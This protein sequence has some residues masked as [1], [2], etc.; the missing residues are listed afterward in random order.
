MPPSCETT[1]PLRRMVPLHMQF[2]TVHPFGGVPQNVANLPRF[3][4]REH[5][6]L[7]PNVFFLLFICF[8]FS[9]LSPL[10]SLPPEF[11]LHAPL[12]QH[13]PG[14]YGSWLHPPQQF[15][16]LLTW[17]KVRVLCPTTM[18]KI[19]STDYSVITHNVH[20]FNF[21]TKRTKAFQ[22]YHTQKAEVLLLQETHFSKTSV[23][24]YLNVKY[25]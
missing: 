4:K 21:P 11:W 25:P 6:G 14:W 1:S 2:R 17:H 10:P 9:P 15:H 16:Q 23:P 3:I 13:G 5:V 20:G 22:F 19:Y 24:R 18:A 7:W 8:L 12:I